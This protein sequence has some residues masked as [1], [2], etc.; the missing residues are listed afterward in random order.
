MSRWLLEVVIESLEKAV[1]WEG[2]PGRHLLSNKLESV[3]YGHAC[4]EALE[5]LN[6]NIRPFQHAHWNIP[7]N[8]LLPC[9]NIQENSWLLQRAQLWYQTKNFIQASVRHLRGSLGVSTICIPVADGLLGDGNSKQT[10]MVYSSCF[11]VQ[12][13]FWWVIW[14]KLFKT[15]PRP[16]R[17][18]LHDKIHATYIANQ[19]CSMQLLYVIY[20][21]ISTD[22]NCCHVSGE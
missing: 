20:K 16:P 8:V 2:L 15:W 14:R 12:I 10:E 11:A 4:K 1:L 5:S 6:I 18:A 3:I 21:E 7:A 17:A 13:L 22:M 9:G 19:P